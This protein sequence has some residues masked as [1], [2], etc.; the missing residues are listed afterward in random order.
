VEVSTDGGSTWSEARLKTPL[1][2][3]TWRLWLYEWT[4]QSGDHDVIVRA[5]DGT[6]A[7]QIGKRAD[8][9]PSGSSGY[10]TVE[11]SA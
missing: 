10:H 1:S 4:A 3:Y 5:Y 9:F 6:G 11:V 2:P 8:P 7:L